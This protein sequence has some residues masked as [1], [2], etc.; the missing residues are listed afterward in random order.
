MNSIGRP[1]LDN[2]ST[3][4]QV[5]ILKSLN[6]L[7]PTVLQNNSLEENVLPK[8]KSHP[9]EDMEKGPLIEWESGA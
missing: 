3:R 4:L 9:L 2:I 1:Y 5:S 8:W 6:F 7:P